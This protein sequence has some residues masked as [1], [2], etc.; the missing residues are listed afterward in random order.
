MY[1]QQFYKIA[2]KAIPTP[3]SP[4]G[5]RPMQN[6]KRGISLESEPHTPTPLIIPERSVLNKKNINHGHNQSGSFING[7]TNG[8]L[9]ESV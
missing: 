5:R 8:I 6:I 9:K 4:D 2:E 3:S 7:A 1:F